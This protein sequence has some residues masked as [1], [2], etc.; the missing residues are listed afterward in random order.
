MVSVAKSP[1]LQFYRKGYFDKKIPVSMAPLCLA[2]AVV[3][4][5]TIDDVADSSEELDFHKAFTGFSWKPVNKL[6]M[7]FILLFF[8]LPL[9]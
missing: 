5:N 2:L 3:T 1:R 6:H 4:R 7:L 8:F 9:N